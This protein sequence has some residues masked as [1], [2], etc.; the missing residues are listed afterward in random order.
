MLFS[1]VRVGIYAVERLENTEAAMGRCFDCSWGLE[2]ESKEK[3]KRF[4]MLTSSFRQ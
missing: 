3:K 2:K 1:S 4:E